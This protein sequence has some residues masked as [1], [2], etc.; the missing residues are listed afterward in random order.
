METTNGNGMTVLSN[1]E[2]FSNGILGMYKDTC[3]K[4]MAA[5]S[6]TKTE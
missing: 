5:I 1:I 2:N 6:G 4:Y 3:K